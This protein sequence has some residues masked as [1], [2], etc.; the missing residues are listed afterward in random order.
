MS[1]GGGDVSNVSASGEQNLVKAT[2]PYGP[3][4]MM[5]TAMTQFADTVSKDSDG[6]LAFEH[7]FADS[8]VK[9]PEVATS[10]DGG[11]IDLGYLGMAYT[12]ASF[13][14]D[15]WASQL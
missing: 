8:L 4:H 13:P 6:Q 14:I 9:Q 15:A 7:Y 11:V 1:T 10:L 12:P 2:P 5:S 3:D